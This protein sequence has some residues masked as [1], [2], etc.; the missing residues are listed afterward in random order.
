MIEDAQMKH[1]KEE[2]DLMAQ[3][4]ELQNEIRLKDDYSSMGEAQKMESLKGM[5]K[6]RDQTIKELEEEIA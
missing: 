5:S 1:L 4:R 3:N 2:N 6:Q